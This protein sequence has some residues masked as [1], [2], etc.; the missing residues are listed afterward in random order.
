MVQ[1]HYYS[2]NDA[3]LTNNSNQDFDQQSSFS[4]ILTSA[5]LGNRP[6]GIRLK[7]LYSFAI[8]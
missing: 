4:L 2:S 3:M 8:S 6:A 7:L 5:E 1:V